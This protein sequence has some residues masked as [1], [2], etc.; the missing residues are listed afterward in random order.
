VGY[1]ESNLLPDE[2]VVYKGRLHWI[3]FMK[4]MVVILLGFIFVFIQ[5]ILGS[6]A[7]LIGM[8]AALPAL[9]DYISSEF[10][11]TNK[12]VVIKVGF[13]RRRT[14]ELLLRHVEAISVDQTIAGRIFNFGSL[15]L[16][17][18]GGVKELFHNITSPLEF[19]RRIQG[20]AS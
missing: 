10:G 19:R 7:M 8:A 3:I 17:G 12:R 14:L 16:T 20:V 11:V 15:T 6:I 9:I 1:I 18:T 5:P 2:Q 13:V 4:P